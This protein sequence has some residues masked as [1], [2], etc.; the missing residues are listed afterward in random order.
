MTPPSYYL[1]YGKKYADRFINKT[2]ATLS[3]AGQAWLL[4][5]RHNLQDAI[6]T[7][8]MKDPDAFD[9]LEQNDAA[10]KKFAYDTHPKAYIDAGLK[11]LPASD[12][13]KIALTPDFSDLF[14]KDGINQMIDVAKTTRPVDVWNVGTA[15]AEDTASA[16]GS[17]ASRAWT[18]V[19][20]WW[21][22]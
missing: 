18:S 12:L 19:T 7:E 14:S 9:K 11:T 17:A 4:R 20:N 3:P 13:A 1:G 22:K 8:R 2:Y 15:T 16:V 21:N 6:E 10:F 5:A